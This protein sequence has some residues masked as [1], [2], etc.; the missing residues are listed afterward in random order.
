MELVGQITVNSKGDVGPIGPQGDQGIQGPRGE[1]FQV[2]AF[3]ELN[4]ARVDTIVATSASATDFYVFVVTTDTR[5]STKNLSGIDTAG[6]LTSL[7]KNVI[8]YDGTTWSNYGQFTGLKG[9]KGDQGNVGPEGPQGDKGDQGVPGNQGL[10][11]TAGGIEHSV[12]IQNVGGNKYVWNNNT[13]ASSTGDNISKRI[14][15]LY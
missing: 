6:N 9:D 14:Y 8:M 10:Q 3:G 11:G 7:D 1:S 2:D 12:I 5:T 15:V 13:S 4:D